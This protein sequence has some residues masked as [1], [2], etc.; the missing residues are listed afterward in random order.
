MDAYP[1][2]MFSGTVS[3]VRLQPVVESNGATIRLRNQP[4]RVIGVLTSKGQ[5]AMGQDQDDTV[6]LP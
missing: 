6:I 4:F 1:G 2:R 5:A 3:Q